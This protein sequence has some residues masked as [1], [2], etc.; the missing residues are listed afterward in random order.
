MS[1]SFDRYLSTAVLTVWGGIL[2]Y[3]VLSGRLESYLHPSFHLLTALS[4][5]ILLL[6]AGGLVFLPGTEE[7]C[8]EPNCEHP[9]SRQSP[10]R[11]ILAAALLVV[12]LSAASIASPDQYGAAIV[13]NRG[14]IKETNNLPG[15]NPNAA[16][17]FSD[18]LDGQA[19]T[20]PGKAAESYLKMN[21][22]GQIQAETV[23]LIFAAEEPS[24]RTDFE[25]KQIDVIGQ[26]M[27][28]HRNNPKGDRFNLVRMF[29]MCCAADA[30]PMAVAVQTEQPPGVP[31]MSWV[32]VVGKAS[33]PIESGRNVPLILAETVTVC[34]PPEE[35]LIY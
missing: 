15:Y 17:R 28:A 26:F 8:C 27:P 32:K 2:A 1:A 13:V 9:H 31:E 10:W 35:T 25:G 34:D 29:M 5:V 3:F 30:R 20:V 19:P 7:L 11:S 14:L 4:A 21:E 12:P 6:L 23:D 16:P 22:A 24:M 18:S 33:F